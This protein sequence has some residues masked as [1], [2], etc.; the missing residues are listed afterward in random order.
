MEE[1]LEVAIVKDD[2]RD[3]SAEDGFE[4]KAILS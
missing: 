2:W 4:M 1:N 3:K